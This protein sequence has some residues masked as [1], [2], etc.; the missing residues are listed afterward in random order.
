[1]LGIGTQN[2]R[3]RKLQK[4]MLGLLQWIQG[5]GGLWGCQSLV[6]QLCSS[7]IPLCHT[8]CWFTQFSQSRVYPEEAKPICSCVSKISPKPLE[9]FFLS[10]VGLNWITC[11]F[12]FQSLELKESHVLTD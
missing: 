10:L 11:A 6:F 4:K 3:T 5:W 8:L 7:C 1:M 2:A 9:D 12:L